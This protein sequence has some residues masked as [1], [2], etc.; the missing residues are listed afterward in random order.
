MG[1]VK[2]IDVLVVVGGSEGAKQFTEIAYALEKP[3]VPIPAFGGIA[4]RVWERVRLFYEKSLG[5]ETQPLDRFFGDI[6]PNRGTEVVQLVEKAATAYRSTPT[7][8]LTFLVAAEVVALTA[9]LALFLSG[10]SFVEIA[11]PLLIVT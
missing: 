7:I 9:W 3:I 11:M 8:S 2:D 1:I 10:A 6:Y 4:E 5:S